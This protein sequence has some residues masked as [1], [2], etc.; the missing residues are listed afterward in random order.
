MISV[1]RA[2]RS[3]G[4]NIRKNRI[5]HLAVITRAGGDDKAR[6]QWPDRPERYIV[7]LRT[8]HV[9]G[10]GPISG[11]DK[12]RPFIDFSATVW[13][14]SKQVL[15]AFVG[16]RGGGALALV[17]RFVRILSFEVYVSTQRYRQGRN[18][19][20]RCPGAELNMESPFYQ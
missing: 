3:A 12:G 8:F 13:N 1:G 19:D 14:C 11:G 2:A 6:R 15:F 20:R 17:N 7:L 16:R 5:G 10:G 18:L 9:P 4:N